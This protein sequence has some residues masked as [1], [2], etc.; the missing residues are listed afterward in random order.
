MNRLSRFLAMAGISLLAVQSN[1]APASK[2]GVWATDFSID[3]AHLTS[4]GRNPYFVLEPGHYRIL[5]GGEEEITM[6]VLDETR[7]VAGVETRVIEERE[8]VNGQLAEISRN[9]FAINKLNQ[10]VL[11]FG[12]EVDMYKDGKVVSHDGSWVAGVNDAKAGL[13]MPG[14][15]RKG[16]R[17]YQEQAPGVAMDRAEILSTTEKVQT[18]AG[19]YEKCLKVVETS[20][21]IRG[22]EYKYFAPGIG[23]IKYEKLLLVKQGMKVASQ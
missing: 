15:P 16:F 18:D 11:Y 23:L 19:T 4:V 10:D 21:M 8:M 22:A 14:K 5:R 2:A 6:T 3:P 12:E 20:P 1:A 7:I 9:F 17:H 13:I